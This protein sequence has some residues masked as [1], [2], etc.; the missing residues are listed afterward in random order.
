MKRHTLLLAGLF[1]ACLAHAAAPA[2]VTA[3]HAW[4]RV[5]PGA[6]PA[7]AYVVLR[8]DGDQPMSLIGANTSDYGEAMLHESSSAGGVNRMRM[9]AALSIP[10]H[11]TQALAPGGY[12]LM[13]MDAKHPIKPGDTVRV[14]LHFD[15][16]ETLQVALPVRPANSR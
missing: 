4:I 8:N 5:L 12:H 7:G 2:Q 11:G 3:S 6:L 14:S 9:I 10:A 1:V 13:L 16:G 15:D